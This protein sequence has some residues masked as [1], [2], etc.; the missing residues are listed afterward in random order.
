MET[1]YRIAEISERSGF[2][3]PT[4]RYYEEI[5]LLPESAR[6]PSGYRVYDDGVLERL[7]FIARAKQ[8]GCTLEEIADLTAAWDA[9][10]CGPVQEG[11]KATVTRKLGETRAKISDLTDFAQEL[12]KTRTVMDTHTPDGPCDDGCGCIS[13]ADSNGCQTHEA[14]PLQMIQSS[15]EPI[16]CTLQPDAVSGRLDEWRALVSRAIRR[17]VLPDGVRLEFAPDVTVAEVTDL[18]IAEQ[19]C[20]RFLTFT[21][22]F[23][24]SVVVLDIHAPADAQEIVA[25]LVE[26]R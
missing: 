9:G 2:S 26:A 17:S 15:T 4:L 1:T 25:G 18:A 11:L 16:A 12:Q 14:M 24:A 3:P 5:G 13:A 7:R 8:L 10:T 20:C 6:T 22:T 23:G 21:V 19:D